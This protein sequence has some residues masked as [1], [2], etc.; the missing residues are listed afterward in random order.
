MSSGCHSGHRERM[1]ARFFQEESF[2]SFADHELLEMRLG[3]T[4]GRKNTNE[5]AHQLLERFGSL[6]GVLEASV[7]DLQKV[8]GIGP[9][10]AADLKLSLE[11][12]RRYI[13]DIFVPAK[14]SDTISEI[15]KFLY[16]KFVGQK[17]ECVYLL[18]LDNSF[19]LIDCRLVSTGTVNQSNVPTPQ[20]VAIACDKKI[21]NVIV[22]H[23]HPQGV[24]APSSADRA[25]TDRLYM[26]FSMMGINLIEHL[27]FSENAFFP[28]LKQFPYRTVE[29][30][31]KDT[32]RSDL[33]EKFYDVDE[34]T[35]TFSDL[36]EQESQKHS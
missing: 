30:I 6:R 21:P 34:T 33:R 12:V 31:E 25:V 29:Q 18:M 20:M 17:N 1:R 2:S 23:N 35:F 28:I 5:I 16:P 13:D 9:I 36:F 26:A 3:A 15:L 7:D 10:V 4:I 19:R 32:L 8:D 22:A 27:V 14:K 11:L 24:A